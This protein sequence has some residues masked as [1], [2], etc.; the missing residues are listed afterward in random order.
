MY[1]HGGGRVNYTNSLIAEVLQTKTGKAHQ[2]SCLPGYSFLPLF[3]F[4][5]T[6]E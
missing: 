3:L 6:I 4:L 1:F 5:V 2:Y